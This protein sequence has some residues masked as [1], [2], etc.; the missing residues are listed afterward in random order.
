MSLLGEVTTEEMNEALRPPAPPA[1][2]E[3]D[4]EVAEAKDI[5]AGERAEYIPLVL[6]A[7]V[8]G[9]PRKCFHNQTL[10]SL[11]AEPDK[12][13]I[14]KQMAIKFFTALGLPPSG[15]STPQE[16]Q[17]LRGRGFFGHEKTNT[18]KTVLKL[19]YP[20]VPNGE[21]T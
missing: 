20:I 6:N 15:P 12:Q 2:G 11:S 19:K 7:L 8:D 9:T 10:R 1:E 3:Y 14:V 17:G 5:A 16:L 13:R 4:F 18:G 21:A